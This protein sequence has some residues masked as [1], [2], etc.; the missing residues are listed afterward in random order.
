MIWMV[1]LGVIALWMGGLLIVSP[2]TLVKISEKMNRMVG[3]L[4]EQVIKYR[5]GVG[6][7]LVL[8]A[9]FLFYFAYILWGR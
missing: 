5:I 3:R 2:A 8:A 7:S 4:D 6:V 9:G 1:V